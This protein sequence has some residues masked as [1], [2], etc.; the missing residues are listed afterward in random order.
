MKIKSFL[1]I[2]VIATLAMGCGQRSTIK[3]AVNAEKLANAYGDGQNVIRKAT[4]PLSDSSLAYSTPLPGFAPIAGGI[5]KF[6]GDIFAANTNMGKLVYSYTQPITPTIGEIPEE[7][8]AVRLKRFFFYMK[9]QGKQRFRD[10]LSRFFLGKGNVTFDFL[11]KLVVNI[12]SVNV[13]DPDNMIPTLIEKDYTSKEFGHMLEIFEKW[14]RPAAVIDTESAKSAVLLRYSS[15]EKSKDTNLNSFGNIHYLEV[16]PEI[17]PG[18]TPEK[19]MELKARATVDTKHLL[20]DHP[21]MKGIYERILILEN[22]LI[23]ELKKDPISDLAFKTVISD[24]N[25][26]LEA[27]GVN[28]IDT[29]T[30]KSCLELRLPDINLVPIARKGNSLKLD[31]VIFAGRVPE[32]FKLKGFVEF[33]VKIDSPI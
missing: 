6:V 15:K 5:L 28:Y 2:A 17:E 14:Y 20:L 26:A 30:P 13:D 27:L 25:E 29:C 1:F 22:S 12:E 32:S 24:T 23:I 31:A 10:I 19:I 9:P 4:F 11:E 21:K 3:N 7:L 18:M 33:E 8:K 16:N